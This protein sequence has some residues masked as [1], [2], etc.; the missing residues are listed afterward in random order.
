L[1]DGHDSFD[2]SAFGPGDTALGQLLWIRCINVLETIKATDL[3]LRDGN[4]S[5]VIVDLVLNPPD[6]VGRIPQTTWYRFQRLVEASSTACV[7]ISRLS[8]VSS[9]QL[10]IVL[11]NAWTLCDLDES[12]LG[13]QISLHLQRSH[14][15]SEF[16]AERSE[17]R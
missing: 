4:F 3:I 11:Q 17:I 14:R 13:S 1:V 7:I 16:R 5:L 9:A 2:P 15:S 10:K 12:N 6:E 8:M